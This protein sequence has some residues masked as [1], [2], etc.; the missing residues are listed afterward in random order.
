MIL[1]PDQRRRRIPPLA[2]P[3][4]DRRHHPILR[5]GPAK[6]PPRQPPLRSIIE[7]ADAPPGRW[8][9]PRQK[10]TG[11]DDPP[12]APPDFSMVFPETVGVGSLADGRVPG[13]SLL[14]M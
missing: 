8:N 5:P 9:G 11:E 2:I 12:L 14:E 1:R 6:P 13:L 7:G 10:K 4:A 3:I